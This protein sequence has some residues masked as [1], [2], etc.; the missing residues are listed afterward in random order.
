MD[1]VN[2]RMLPLPEFGAEAKLREAQAALRELG[3]RT[4]LMKGRGIL[5]EIEEI[6]GQNRD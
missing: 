6:K 5:A 2:V 4:Q 3:R 1:K